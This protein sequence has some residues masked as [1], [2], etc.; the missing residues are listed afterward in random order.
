MAIGA[1]FTADTIF[2]IGGAPLPGSPNDVNEALSLVDTDG[3]GVVDSADNCPT[4]YNPDQADVDGDGV[5]DA[6]DNCV[7]TF[8]P[9]Q[10]DTDGDGLGDLCDDKTEK[11][12]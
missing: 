5:G 4:V 11:V 7:K 1:P 10:L 6:C 8:N 3:D 9:E 2:A 12:S